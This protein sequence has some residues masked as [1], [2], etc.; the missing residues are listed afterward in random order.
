MWRQPRER[1]ERSGWAWRFV[2]D[3]L[4]S[5]LADCSHANLS[6]KLF[7]HDCRAVTSPRDSVRPSR[8]FR[9]LPTGH[10]TCAQMDSIADPCHITGDPVPWISLINPLSAVLLLRVLEVTWNRLEN[11]G[12]PHDVNRSHFLLP[13]SEW[14][15]PMP[16]C[17]VP[18]RELLLAPARLNPT[19]GA[20]WNRQL[21]ANTRRQPL[22][23]RRVPFVGSAEYR[24]GSIT[25]IQD[26]SWKALGLTVWLGVKGAPGRERAYFSSSESALRSFL[27][28]G[29]LS[30]RN[31]SLRGGSTWSRGSQRWTAF[32]REISCIFYSVPLSLSLSS[33][34]LFYRRVLTTGRCR[35]RIECPPLP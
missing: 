32:W 22:F 33:L 35:S 7:I 26:C 34:G 11:T 19:V 28:L 4:K 16:I 6:G 31:L 23:L 25:S 18:A 20:L 5:S 24:G 15:S 10:F 30:I 12:I 9:G 21:W 14:I 27:R 1:C 8:R 3:P 29:H 17:T 2:S 13:R